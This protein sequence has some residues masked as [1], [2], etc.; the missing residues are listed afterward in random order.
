M[1]WATTTLAAA[2]LAATAASARQIDT[3]ELLE[4][5]S[6]DVVVIGEVHDNP[7]HHANQTLA[8]AAMGARAL[9]FEMLTDAEARRITPALVADEA[10][11]ERT[12]GWSAKGWPDFA[13]YYPIF[14]AVPSAA[15]YG[16]D[17]GR[18]TVRR[19]M[20]EGASAVM[21][22]SGALFGLDTALPRDVQER[23]E[24]DQLAAHCDALPEEILP[25][26]VEA[27]RLRDA[28]LARAVIAAYLDTGGPVVVITGNGHART[29]QAIPAM[30]ARAMP[31]LSVTS[32]AQF[33]DTAPETPPFDYWLITPAAPRE[34]PCA[35]FRR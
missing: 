31:D 34:D 21:G 16:G 1:R 3:A 5:P 22:A 6:A 27:Q 18:E 33:E 26:M 30:L 29:D 10:A 35:G 15:I 14:T 7:L 24:A 23:R 11:L 13:W 17:I 19:A 9:V 2:A 8:T 12:L 20:T 4:L 32:I 28:A 25:G